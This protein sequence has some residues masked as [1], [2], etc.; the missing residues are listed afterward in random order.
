MREKG[1]QQLANEISTLQSKLGLLRSE[2]FRKSDAMS[3]LE[4]QE[5]RSELEKI[6]N[7]IDKLQS[8][9]AKRKEAI[10]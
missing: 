5:L 7:D 8:R 3:F 10:S 1:V 9:Y 4:N 6:E 2:L